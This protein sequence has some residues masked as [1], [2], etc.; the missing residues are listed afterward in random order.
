VLR[1]LR[2]FTA[3]LAVAVPVGNPDIFQGRGAAFAVGNFVIY[4]GVFNGENLI[5]AWCTVPESH[6][7]GLGTGLDRRS[8]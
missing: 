8:P 4:L 7:N 3:L 5:P 1:S 2:R 6:R